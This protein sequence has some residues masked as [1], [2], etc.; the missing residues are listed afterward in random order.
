MLL[1]LNQFVHI[2]VIKQKK[3]EKAVVLG[4]KNIDWRPVLHCNQIEINAEILPV[5]LT[6]QGGSLGVIQMHI[7]LIPVLSK[8]EVLNED[9]VMKQLS[10]EK[11]FET[12][13]L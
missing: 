9:S 6:H 7:D 12:E 2:T 5:D 11:R 4:T 8:T 1:K 3:G 10:L 13:S